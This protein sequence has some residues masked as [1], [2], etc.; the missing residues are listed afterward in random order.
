MTSQPPS[1]AS[2]A[3]SGRVVVA[4]SGGVDSSVAAWH[5]VREGRDVVGLFMRN[6]VSVEEAESAK[7]SC[8]SS[9]DA[10][11]A[12]MV[13][14]HLGIAFQA[15]DLGGEFSEVIRYFIS[16][17]QRGRTPN[18]CA[19]CNRDL[20]FD[21]LLRFA[22]ELGATSVATGHYAR[23]RRTPDGR[24]IV[25]RGVDRTKDQ[26][27]QLFSVAEENLARTELPLGEWTKPQVRELADRAGL[28]TAS[29][30][31]SQEICFVPSNDYRNLLREH[32]A[33][34]HPGKLVDT[35]GRVLGDHPGTEWFTI[36]QRRGLGVAAG[37]P[38]FV[39]DLVP[40]TGTV[41]LGG[42][43]E[44]ESSW[45]E[46]EELNLIGFDVPRGGAFRAACQVRY[47]HEPV[48]AL[49]EV[50]GSRAHVTFDQPVHAVAPGQG[51]ALYALEAD[52]DWGAGERLL[53]GGW[54]GA[55]DTGTVSA[56]PRPSP[57]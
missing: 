3:A 31:D 24:P 32:D 12:R 56:A 34:L 54:I 43:E 15:V 27:Y 53:G 51:G 47:H 22:T 2:P 1:P 11:D 7:K 4:M 6:G 45:I 10:R 33:A 44:C 49:V 20:K 17:Y 13:A 50:D 38:L 29:K 48:P 28:R 36:G 52:G 21:A 18:P 41:V 37:V 42:R 39:V 16:E 46:L 8:C 19:V 55:R 26:S 35:A 5:L 30:P 9:V 14:A 40:S 57:E 25:L 23:M